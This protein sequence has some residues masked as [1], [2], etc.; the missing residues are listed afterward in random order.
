VAV[1]DPLGEQVEH[2]GGGGRADAGRIWKIAGL[3]VLSTSRRQDAR[4]VLLR[5]G[6]EIRSSVAV[7]IELG[8]MD[9]AYPLLPTIRLTDSPESLLPRW[10]FMPILLSAD[11]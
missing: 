6:R 1:R 8:D 9:A 2:R 7:H 5:S 11:G 3:A 10:G 4:R